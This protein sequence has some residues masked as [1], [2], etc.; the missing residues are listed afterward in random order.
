MLAPSTLTAPA[1][2][3]AFDFVLPG[4]EAISGL[5]QIVSANASSAAT[6][7]ADSD[8]AAA[9]ASAAALEALT[10]SAG[11]GACW[12]DEPPEHPPLAELGVAQSGLDIIAG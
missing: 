4:S 7:A 11:T 8:G 5:A 1:V 3:F 9:G 6:A 12:A 10:S 2:G